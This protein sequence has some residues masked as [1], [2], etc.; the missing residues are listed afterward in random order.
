MTQLEP[1]LQD[2][3]NWTHQDTPLWEEV[4]HSA[5]LQDFHSWDIQYQECWEEE[6]LPEGASLV[7]EA[8][9]DSPEDQEVST[10]QEYHREQEDNKKVT[11]WWVI[12]CLSTMV[13]LC[14][15]KNF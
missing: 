3:I 9:E 11:D 1:E 13:I 6:D 12:L 5:R 10:Y 4:S 2:R 15:P 8:A 14:R 7:G